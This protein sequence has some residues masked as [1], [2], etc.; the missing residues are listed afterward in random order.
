MNASDDIEIIQSGFSP[1]VSTRSPKKK[2][3]VFDLDETIG[4][5]YMFYYFWRFLQHQYEYSPRYSMEPGYMLDPVVIHQILD[6]YPEFFRPG[7]FIIFRYIAYKKKADHLINMWIYTN[8]ALS[9]K[10]PD[11]IQKY[12]HH[13]VSFDL[14]DTIVSAFR[15]K[16]RRV[17]VRRMSESKVY[18]DIHCIDIHANRDVCFIDNDYHEGMIHCRVFY[19]K[20]HSYRHCLSFEEILRRFLGSTLALDIF[21]RMEFS[22]VMQL[23][24]AFMHKEQVRFNIGKGNSMK[25]HSISLKLLEYIKYFFKTVNHVAVVGR[26]THKRDVHLA[27]DNSSH[28]HMNIKTRKR[29]TGMLV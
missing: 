3:V 13:T 23:L 18:S 8:N 24:T 4:D 11:M 2:L 22:E 28:S 15:I 19:I 6:M 14:F 7:I 9:P 26:R 10:F 1:Y 17:D 12:I 25:E 21:E 27:K 5:F 16:G 20:P 29:H